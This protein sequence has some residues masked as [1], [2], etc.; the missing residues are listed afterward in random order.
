MADELNIQILPKGFGSYLDGTLPADQ[1]IAAGA[2]SMA[3]QQVK[4]IPTVDPQK[5]G[6][7]VQS[8]ETNYQLPATAGT[9]VPTDVDTASA[10]LQKIALGGGVFGTYTHSD[11][12]GAM[13]GLPYPLKEV[14]ELIK[15]A[16]TQ[17]L[18][19]LYANIYALTNWGQAEA[20]AIFD[21]YSGNNKHKVTGVQVIDSGGGYTSP[22]TVTINSGAG[23]TANAIIG[24]DANNIAT[25]GKV[26][27]ILLDD[28]ANVAV[29]GS[30]IPTVTLSA[31]PSD[32]LGTWPTRN[33][34]ITANI[35]AANIELGNISTANS[36]L[37][38]SLNLNWN[39]LGTALKV[40]QRARYIGL[41]PVAI[42]R[43]KFAAQF[44]ND[45]YTFVDS[46]S[47]Y[48]VDT[49]PHGA[50][51]SIE[52]ISDRCTV[53]GQSMIALMRQERNQARLQEIGIP[54]DNTIPDTL[55]ANVQQQL[56]NQGTVQGA[57]EG[58]PAAEAASTGLIAEATAGQENYTIPAN[59]E[60]VTCA[61]EPIVPTALS[62]IEPVTDIS[63]T[64]I[65]PPT[66][67]LPPELVT[68]NS[69]NVLSQSTFTNGQA[70][71]NVTECNCDCWVI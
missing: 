43:D 65:Q 33:N 38:N 54:L 37:A 8:L 7:I 44:P 6:Q 48:A 14:Y 61:N 17:D 4:N 36:M 45:L 39:I 69:A 11:F 20:V 41:A 34:S 25:Y 42:P 12:V 27:E 32:G 49:L 68:T 46:A 19:N 23:A 28:P 10:G 21:Y 35:V 51:Q 13:T 66:P 53:G 67:I 1:A 62:V 3:M 63:V 58:I 56:F 59:Y 40:E 18:G 5:F 70:T 71:Q 50:A 16:Q 9:D 52:S 30:T 29:A 64:V 2:F 26:I 31:P 47:D 57:V 22:P 15:Q 55:P 24:T 60:T